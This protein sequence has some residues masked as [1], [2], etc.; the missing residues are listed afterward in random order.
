RLQCCAVGLL[1]GERERPRV[2]P[3]PAQP[4]IM[5]ER[6]GAGVV[7]QTM[8]QQQ[9]REPMPRT[10]Q[11]AAGVLTRPH[12][13]TRRLLVRLRDAHRH[14]LAEA[15]LAS[16]SASRRSVLT[17]SPEARGIFDGAATVQAIP[18]AAQARAS[19]YPVGPASYAT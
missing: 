5:G 7:D 18:T 9:L 6:P 14:Q 19:P 10:H 8:P 13:I 16:R 17:S 15:Q 4:T 3:L 12:Q 2:E 11:L 1:E